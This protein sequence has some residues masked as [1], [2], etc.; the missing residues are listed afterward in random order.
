MSRASKKKNQTRGF[1][2]AMRAYKDRQSRERY[3]HH[4]GPKFASH[5]KDHRYLNFASNIPQTLMDSVMEGGGGGRGLA[6]GDK[7]DMED[8]LQE[9]KKFEEKMRKRKKNQ[10]P[11]SKAVREHMRHMVNFSTSHYEKEFKSSYPILHKKGEEETDS[12]SEGESGGGDNK[13][14]VVGDLKQSM[15]K[16]LGEKLNLQNKKIP[17]HRK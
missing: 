3:P 12:E 1:T 10:G 2:L 13:R 17:M 14:G 15:I 5:Y 8:I 11:S 6:S 9:S 4:E 16:K 7:K